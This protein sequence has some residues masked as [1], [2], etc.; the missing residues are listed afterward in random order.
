M[1]SFPQP[2]PRMRQANPDEA[3]RALQSMDS[4]TNVSGLSDEG[5]DIAQGLG[6]FQPSEAELMGAQLRAPGGISREQI[7]KG[8]L[9]KVKQMLR[10]E[11]AKHAQKLE[12]EGE[13]TK[14]AA[15]ARTAQNEAIAARQREQAEMNEAT[16]AA[17]REDAQAFQ[18]QQQAERLAAQQQRPTQGQQPTGQMNTELQKAREQYMGRYKTL[19]PVRKFLGREQPGRG[20]LTGSLEAARLRL[21]PESTDLAQAALQSLDEGLT[22]EQ[23]IAQAA[24]QGVELSEREKAYL[25]YAMGR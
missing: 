23:A 9:S 12:L 14:A 18:V 6:D 16:R 25:R 19:D 22:A 20:A 24:S 3:L 11:G 10:M 7:R 2:R 17:A 5:L 21:A 8:A 15:Q 13:K 4:I 1:A